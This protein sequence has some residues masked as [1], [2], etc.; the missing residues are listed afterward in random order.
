M[1]Y[2]LFSLPFVCNDCIKVNFSLAF[3]PNFDKLNVKSVAK[4]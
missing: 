1:N 2:I 4:K 3:Y